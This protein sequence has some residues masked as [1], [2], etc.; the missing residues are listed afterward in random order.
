MAEYAWK[1]WPEDCPECGGPLQVFSD[2][3]EDG[4]AYDGD[5]VRCIDPECGTTGQITADAE[6]CCH[7][8]FLWEDEDQVSGVWL[9]G[10][11]LPVPAAAA[12]DC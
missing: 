12:G 3:P 1:D 8:I 11:D 4:W 6:E 2:D 9:P 5:K 7:A 10:D